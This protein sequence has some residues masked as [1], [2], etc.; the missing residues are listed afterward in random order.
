M[1]IDP[2]TCARRI[3]LASCFAIILVSAGTATAQLEG[4]RPEAETGAEPTTS[5]AM[6][7]A[8][9][10]TATTSAMDMGNMMQRCRTNCQEVV[11]SIENI[12]QEI[13]QAKASNDPEKM[14]QALERA[15]QPLQQMKENM[16]MCLNMMNMMSGMHDGMG[17]MGGES[18]G[19]GMMKQ[20]RE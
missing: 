10:G 1:K 9:T 19:M 11:A 3:T 18:G 13:A 6:S 14:R 16:S 5:P 7:A 12:E 17:M 2:C 4:V 15:Q 20:G 8:T